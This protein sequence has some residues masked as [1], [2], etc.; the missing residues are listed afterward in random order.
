MADMKAIAT[1]AYDLYHGKVAKDFTN[2]KD[3]EKQLR[4]ALIEANGGSSKITARS[5]RDH[6]RELFAMIEVA[7]EPILRE[8]FEGDE[9]RLRAVSALAR[10]RK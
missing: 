4:E 7:V 6:G 3:P 5:L 9:F 8:G 1:L 10:R 2:G